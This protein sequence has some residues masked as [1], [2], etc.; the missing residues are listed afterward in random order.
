MSDYEAEQRAEYIAGLRQLADVLE[1]HPEQSLPM[2]REFT[3]WARDY[4]GKTWLTP[5]DRLEV[6][7]KSFPGTKHK[8]TFVYGDCNEFWLRVHLHGISV[9][10]RSDREQTCTKRV[11][12]TKRVVE[13][14]VDP[15][16]YAKLPRTTVEREE[17]IIEW[18]CPKILDRP[19]RGSPMLV[20][21]LERS[22]AEVSA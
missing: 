5:V 4:D 19:L 7:S 6:F 9:I 1:R 22:L 20:D 3:C 13:T 2:D 16:E 10:C 15:A 11:V 12:G 8:D 18:D 17:E 21:Q 14:V